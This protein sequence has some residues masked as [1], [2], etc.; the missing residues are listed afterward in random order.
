MNEATY[1]T[2]G[3]QCVVKI[4]TLWSKQR[5]T[6]CIP[7]DCARFNRDIKVGR[8]MIAHGGIPAVSS[9]QGI[10]LVPRGDAVYLYGHF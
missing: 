9:V 8:R 6:K 4:E 1:C 3:Q 2:I 10:D 7:I 5:K